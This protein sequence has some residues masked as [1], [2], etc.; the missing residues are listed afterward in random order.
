M[1]DRPTMTAIRYRVGSA[2]ARELVGGRVCVERCRSAFERRR[3]EVVVS[4]PNATTMFR[5]WF[6]RRSPQPSGCTDAGEFL[7]RTPRRPVRRRKAHGSFRLIEPIGL[8]KLAVA[9]PVRL[10]RRCLQ[11]GRTHGN[12]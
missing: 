8:R 11:K 3:L 1:R 5:L 7:N 4:A 2:K 10:P 6:R 9:W 12:R